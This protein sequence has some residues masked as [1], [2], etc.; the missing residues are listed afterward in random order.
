MQPEQKPEARMS[1]VDQL[2]S[3]AMGFVTA[4]ATIAI[5]AL[6][7]AE[8]K[9]DSTIQSGYDGENDT[10]STQPI[11]EAQEAVTTLTGK[12][13]LIALVTVL[14]IVLALVVGF[15]QFNK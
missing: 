12:F 13:S 5:G 6:V 9:S 8:I 4:G 14:S 2:G 3:L 15:K 7:L 10:N 11:S 1:I